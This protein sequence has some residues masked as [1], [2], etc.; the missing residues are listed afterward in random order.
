MEEYLKVMGFSNI[1]AL[2]A[3]HFALSSSEERT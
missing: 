2:T 3:P 1:H